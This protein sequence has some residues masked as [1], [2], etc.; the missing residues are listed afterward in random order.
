VYFKNTG[1]NA[2]VAIYTDK[3]GAPGNLIAQSNIQAITTSGWNTFTVPESALEAGNY[4]LCVVSSSPSAIGVMTESSTNSHVW[5]TATYAGDYPTT[6]GTPTWY[7]KTTTS[8]YATYT[9]I[10]V[11]KSS[12]TP[13]PTATPTPTSTAVPVSSMIA[14]NVNAVWLEHP[15]VEFLDKN[16]KNIVQKL[17]D[18]EI[19]I[20][21]VQIGNWRQTS[22]IVKINY[23]WSSQTIQNT[24]NA[25]KSYS[26]NQI[27]VH[28]WVI[29]SG[30][31]VD[32]GVLVNLGNSAIRQQAVNVAVN[33]VTTY[34]FDGFNDDLYEGFSGT[35]NNYVSYANALGNAL[36]AI[37]KKSSC[38]LFAMYATD[39][40]TLYGG[41]TQMTYVCPMFYDSESWY[42]QWTT[43]QL[44]EVLTYSSCKVLAGLSVPMG[45]RGITL[46][47]QLNWIGHPT[48]TKFEGISLW[49]LA[50][51]QT[52]D[53]TA[54]N[55]W[56]N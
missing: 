25:I 50:Y 7:E 8:I 21:F 48:N 55:N 33:C 23:W 46:T 29:W 12:P 6:F 40:P 43:D 27:E 32:G 47:Q 51:M 9:T 13:T 36:N 41:I 49:S 14:S 2:K 20:V 42:Q 54:W 10:V 5:K 3:E 18:A 38:D 56:T 31:D 1:Y 39:I 30:P 44:Q 15:D 34:G 45:E 28:A 24:I 52:A 53:W 37:N 22:N 19:D 16:Q 35:D 4:W 26:N 11:S 17:L